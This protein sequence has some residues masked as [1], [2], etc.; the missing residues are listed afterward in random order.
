MS[1]FQRNM[2]DALGANG[3]QDYDPTREETLFGMIAGS[4]RGKMRWMVMLVWVY[5]LVFTALAVFAAVSFFLADSVKMWIF[6][7]ALFLMACNFIVVVKLWYWMLLN[8]NSIT[9]EIKRL[10][11]RI[12]KLTQRLTAAGTQR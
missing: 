6:Y 4:F 9:R 2:Q 3:D 1:E 7:A 8:K 5:A 12:A 11:L 10:E